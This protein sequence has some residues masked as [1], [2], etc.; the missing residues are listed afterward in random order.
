MHEPYSEIYPYYD[1]LM[2]FIDYKTWIHY[3]EKLLFRD[4]IRDKEIFDLACGTGE[5]LRI[6]AEKGFLVKGLDASP[7]ML[8]V[9]REKLK[10]QAGLSLG[11]MRNFRLAENVPIIT[12]LYDSL[13]YLLTEDELSSCFRSVYGA[14]KPAGIFVFDMNTIFCLESQWDNQTIVRENSHVYSIWRNTWDESKSI[15]TLRVTLF[16]KQSEGYAK[17]EEVHQ[18]RGYAVEAIRGLLEKAGFAGIEM[19][20]HMTFLPVMETTSRIMVKAR[21]P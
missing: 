3:I 13:N 12:C 7:G 19:F 20:Q 1:I 18:E 15:S 17:N 2:S 4:N 10:D 16:V 21:R 9:A 11:D 14:L 6:W 5:C 8:N